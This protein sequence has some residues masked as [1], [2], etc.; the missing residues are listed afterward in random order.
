MT[1]KNNTE[2][3]RQR[4]DGPAVEGKVAEFTLV[5]QQIH[6]TDGPV[7]AS[8]AKDSLDRSILEGPFKVRDARLR[9]AGVLPPV[10][11]PDMG[12][13]DRFETPATKHFGS[14]FHILHRRMVGRRQERYSIAGFQKFWSR[15]RQGYAPVHIL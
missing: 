2:N 8:V 1:E 5:R 11:V 6:Q 15:A 4:A 14:S 10:H 9:L 12:A 3:Q 7:T 13:D